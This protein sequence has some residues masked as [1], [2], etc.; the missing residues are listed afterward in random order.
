MQ[1][2][3][4]TDENTVKIG[5]LQ[6]KHDQIHSSDRCGLHH[7][8]LFQGL[9]ERWPPLAEDKLI[10]YLHICSH[11]RSI[12]QTWTTGRA[13]STVDVPRLARSDRI[14]SPLCYFTCVCNGTC[15]DSCLFTCAA[16]CDVC[17]ATR[18]VDWFDVMY[19]I[20]TVLWKTRQIQNFYPFKN[21]R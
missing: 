21:P 12:P 1:Q 18:R 8:S 11:I 2:W 4:R 6:G 13:L 15:W 19:D 9:T 3:S 5:A 10:N 14:F 17:S 7:I 20:G 16:E